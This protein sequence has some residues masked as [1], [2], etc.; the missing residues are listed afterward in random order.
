VG[1]GRREAAGEAMG[2]GDEEIA[3]REMERGKCRGR[4]S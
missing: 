3:M 1:R 4:G 2:N